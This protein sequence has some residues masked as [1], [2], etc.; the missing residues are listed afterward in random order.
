MKKTRYQMIIA[1]MLLLFFV[2]GIGM[3][4]TITIFANEINQDQ[5]ND[6][7]RG[8]DGKWRK[9]I[10]VPEFDFNSKEVGIFEIL[11][12]PDFP[13]PIEQWYNNGPGD[14]DGALQIVENYSD[15]KSNRGLK[16]DT[17]EI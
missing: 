12:R 10:S 5:S 2:M 6:W 8:E 9:I 11:D 13:K 16:F 14:R 17:T 4:W 1:C 15:A 7:V 3:N